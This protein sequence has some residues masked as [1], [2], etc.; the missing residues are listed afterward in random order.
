MK[1]YIIDWGEKCNGARYALIQAGSLRDAWWDADMIGGPFKIEEL[2]IP[3]SGYGTRYME[4]SR[5][6]KPF[7]GS[8]FDDLK[9]SQP[10]NAMDDV[11]YHSK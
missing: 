7:D 1:T 5:P 3:K 6:K 11:L 10:T 8:S 2:R 9:W 4:I